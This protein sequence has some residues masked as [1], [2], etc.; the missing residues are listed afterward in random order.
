M[1]SF[2]ITFIRTLSY[3]NPF[4]NLTFI[5][6]KIWCLSITL[7]GFG[8][9]EYIITY[10][11]CIGQNIK[12]YNSLKVNRRFGETCRPPSVVSACHLLHAN[13]LIGLFFDPEYGGE[14][15]LRRLTFNGLYGVMS[16]KTELFII[17][18]VRISN[19]T[20]FNLDKKEGWRL[21]TESCS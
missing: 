3:L 8:G 18:A 10:K 13:F 21:G 17:T 11:R 16:Q 4:H 6:S 1:F 7:C 12:P 2:I 9:I 19:P 15:F 20:L 14:M 5:L